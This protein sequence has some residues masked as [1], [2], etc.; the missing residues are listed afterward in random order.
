MSEKYH[1]GQEN[2]E[3]EKKEKFETIIE[4]MFPVGEESELKI[5][6]IEF[7]ENYVI[8]HIC[9]TRGK[10]G[11]QDYNRIILAD[12]SKYEDQNKDSLEDLGYVIYS[13]L[14]IDPSFNPEI[15][16]VE[17]ND[18]V[19]VQYLVEMYEDDYDGNYVGKHT[20]IR[21]EQ[22]KTN[23]IYKIMS[24]SKSKQESE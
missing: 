24:E 3:K 12:I 8:A 13:N 23:S 6:Q 2:I 4:K 10:W 7:S 1:N 14:H 11:H 5:L 20:E 22:F 9:E 17:G 19:T 16:L 21:T 15:H 18:S